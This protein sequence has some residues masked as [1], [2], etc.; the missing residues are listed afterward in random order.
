MM[1]TNLHPSTGVEDFKILEFLMLRLDG[2]GFGDIKLAFED[3]CLWAEVEYDEGCWTVAV[4]M[5]MR[6]LTHEDAR[7]IVERLKNG[8][9]GRGNFTRR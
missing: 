2:L 3:K 7:G 4:I 9:Y 1:E 5:T 8:G 6:I